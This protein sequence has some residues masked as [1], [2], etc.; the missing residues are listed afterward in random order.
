MPRMRGRQVI[1]VSYGKMLKWGLKKQENHFVS[2]ISLIKK[3]PK[4][5]KQ[6][7]GSTE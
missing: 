2:L 7:S 3:R 1:I 6:P 5:Y 4:I